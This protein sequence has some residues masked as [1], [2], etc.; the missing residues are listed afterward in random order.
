MAPAG[1]QVVSAAA[2]KIEKLFK[3]EQ[4][5][6]TIYVRS[7]D[8]RTLY[9]YAHLEAYA[10]GLREGQSVDQGQRLGTVGSTGN[11]DPASP[12]LHFAIMRTAPNAD[13]WQ[14][15]TAINPYPLL[16]VQN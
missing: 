9:Y 4:G 5:G 8:R 13:W 15:T 7:P 2:G 14:P 10:S 16:T 11:A 3:S 6:N 1:T 12:H